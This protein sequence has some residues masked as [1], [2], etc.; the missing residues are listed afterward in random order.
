M[1]KNKPGR[2]WGPKYHKALVVE[3]PGQRPSTETIPLDTL[4]VKGEDHWTLTD[5]PTSY[6]SSLLLKGE[7]GFSFPYPFWLHLI[8]FRTIYIL[9][10]K[11]P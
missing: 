6:V 3:L 1:L 11:G 2:V 10:I 5:S 7:A 8:G 9:S 4:E